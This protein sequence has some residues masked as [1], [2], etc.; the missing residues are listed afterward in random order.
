MR[1]QARLLQAKLVLARA[2]SSRAVGEVVRL[3]C[4]NRIRNRGLAFD[5]TGW[6]P[7]SVGR[8]AFGVHESAEIRFIRKYLRD[9]AS[10]IEL[11]GNVGVAGSH[12]L[13]VMAPSGS[14]ISVE[15]NP[16]LMPALRK[17]LEVHRCGRTVQVIHAAIASD[18]EAFLRVSDDDLSSQLDEAGTKVPAIKLAE[19]AALAPS[20]EYVL[21]S[22]IEGAEATFISDPDALRRCSKMVIELHT[23]T[24]YGVLW[25]VEALLAALLAQGF[26]LVDRHG[27]V[28]VLERVAAAEGQ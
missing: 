14:L 25:S 9:T 18:A 13:S 22:D 17:T 8:V 12:L 6:D 4:R 3:V 26:H 20:G 10:A 16:H 1:F 5:C 2:L 7:R 15:A 28:C 23:S 19:V 11:G 24:H 27:N 21:L